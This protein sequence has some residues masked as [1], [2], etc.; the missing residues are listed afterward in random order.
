MMATQVGI[1]ALLIVVAAAML[2][3]LASERDHRLRGS[4]YSPFFSADAAYCRAVR[5]AIAPSC[6]RNVMLL[7]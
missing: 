2:R 5:A 1:A 7:E 4:S 3:P 6:G